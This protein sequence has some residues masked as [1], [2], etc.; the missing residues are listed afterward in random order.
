MLESHRGLIFRKGVAPP[1]AD[2]PMSETEE[3]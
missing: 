2:L 3:R 1:L